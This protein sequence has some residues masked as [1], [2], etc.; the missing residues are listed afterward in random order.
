MKRK[1]KISLKLKRCQH[2]DRQNMKLNITKETATAQ[3]G[4]TKRIYNTPIFSGLPA[5]C[6]KMKEVYLQNDLLIRDIYVKTLK[7]PQNNV[8]RVQNE[9]KRNRLS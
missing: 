7:K 5:G 1:G 6:L 3:F 2:V 4:A 9:K 8:V